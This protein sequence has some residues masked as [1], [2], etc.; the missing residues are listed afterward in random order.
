[1]ARIR[2]RQRVPT[3]SKAALDLADMCAREIWRGKM[4]S[5]EKPQQSEEEILR[6]FSFPFLNEALKI[7]SKK[8]PPIS[9]DLIKR[10]IITAGLT[11]LNIQKANKDTEQGIQTLRKL[12]SHE[13]KTA[14]NDVFDVDFPRLTANLTIELGNAFHKMSA[15]D[16]TRGF[17][18][19][20]SRVLFFAAPNLPVFMYSDPLGEKLKINLKDKSAGVTQYFEAMS[21]GLGDN[22]AYLKDYQMPF[23]ANKTLND[24]FWEIAR[25]NGWWQRRVLDLAC[26]INLTGTQPKKS[27]LELVSYQPRQHP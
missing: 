26:V 15:I 24:E 17:F 23:F 3:F 14:L 13:L 16:S 19:L 1:M 18:P 20:A 8:Y 22:W 10:F 21:E 7:D 5:S 4:Y 9:V 27:L 11:P 25:A 2:K 6:D 12:I